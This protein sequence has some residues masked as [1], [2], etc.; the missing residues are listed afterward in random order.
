MQEEPW[1][2]PNE[3]AEPQQ[4]VFPESTKPATEGNDTTQNRGS[5]GQSDEPQVPSFDQQTEETAGTTSAWPEWL[6][7]K[8][9]GIVGTSYQAPQ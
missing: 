7:G 1:E 8:Q 2:P 4:E 9:M 6:T 3:E 5:E